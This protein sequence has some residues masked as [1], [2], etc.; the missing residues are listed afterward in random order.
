LIPPLEIP[1]AVRRLEITARRQLSGT[2]A[3]EYRSHFR[4]RGME[5]A[6][7]RPYQVGDDPRQLDWN[8]T[9]RC[10]TPQVR[11]YQEERSRTLTLLADVSLSCTPAKRLLLARCAALLAFAAVQNRDRVALIAFSDRTEELIPPG[12]GRNHALRI[13]STLLGLSPKGEG[14]DLNSPLDAALA[15]NRRPG[16]L[17]LLSDFHAPLPDE[18]LR[19]ALA[20]HD[21]LAL[22]L[23]DYRER[24][25]PGSGLTLVADAESGARRLVDLGSRAA[26]ASMEKAWDD[27]DRLLAAALQRL[28]IDHAFVDDEAE[29]LP[30]LRSL[31]GSRRRRER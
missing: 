9:A 7:I 4:G 25:W 10:G 8:L 20:R 1:A 21:L 13:L 6:E 11:I 12:S 23:R 28:G 30:A 15:L 22:V 19:C 14:T 24:Q 3:G 16:M 31:F 29:P 26:R 18:L 5:F 17:I 27:S 2:L